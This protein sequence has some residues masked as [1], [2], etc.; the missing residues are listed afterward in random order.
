MTPA[1]TT[2]TVVVARFAAIVAVEA[3]T[4]M[5][6]TLRFRTSSISAGM[7]SLLPSANRASSVSFPEPRTSEK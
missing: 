1:K 7:R 2:G 6:S 3:P 5:T 4:T